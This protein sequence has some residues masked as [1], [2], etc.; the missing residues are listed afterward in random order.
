MSHQHTALHLRENVNQ[1]AARFRTKK[2]NN[3]FQNSLFSEM[4]LVESDTGEN[5]GQRRSDAYQYTN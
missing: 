4:E 2:R 3:L 1:K 5:M